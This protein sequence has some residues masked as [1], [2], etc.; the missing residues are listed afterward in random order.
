MD[1]LAAFAL[2]SALGAAGVASVIIWA[3]D[4]AAASSIT[5]H[6]KASE[7]I[8]NTG[9]P[10]ANWRNQRKDPLANLDEL[11]KFFETCRFFEDEFA[12]EQL[13]AQ[14]AMVRAD[15]TRRASL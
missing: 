5:R 7:H 8:L 4:R 6:F 3:T 11:I 10:P 12:R 2:A 15:W 14:L 1:L 13:L 9:E